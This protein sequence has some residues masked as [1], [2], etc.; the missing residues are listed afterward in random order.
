MRKVRNPEVRRYFEVR[1]EGMSEGMR[2]VASEP[3]LNKISAFVTDPH[4][5]H[6]VGQQK[7][8]F[9]WRKVLE[10][11]MWVVINLQKG[12]LGEEAVTLGSLFLS[13]IKNALFSRRSHDLFTLYCDEVQNLM[14]FDAGLDTILSESR[15]FGISVVSANQFLDQYPPAMRSA[16][17]AVGT[18]VLFQLAS[19]DAQ[20]MASALDGGKPL[21]ELLKNLA[22]RHAIVKSG[23]ESWQEIVAP[24]VEDSP[25]AYSDLYDRCRKRWARRRT[26]IEKEITNKYVNP[27][28]AWR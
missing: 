16:I 15:K 20:H 27:I 19:T 8:T 25:V 1:Y 4:F 11:G 3:I 18:H 23:S 26:D 28:D 24:R 7:S 2:R 14:A 22:H 12:R 13:M 5:R 17:L 21:A 6:I 10:S 9:S